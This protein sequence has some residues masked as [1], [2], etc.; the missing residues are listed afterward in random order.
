ML[1]VWISQGLRAWLGLKSRRGEAVGAVQVAVY[2][3]SLEGHPHHA[4]ASSRQD[5]SLN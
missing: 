1:K 4:C 5:Q 3:S 2:F